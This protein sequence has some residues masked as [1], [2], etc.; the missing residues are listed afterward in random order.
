MI[1]K[2]DASVT[3]YF[4]S[5]YVSSPELTFGFL[6]ALE[7]PERIAEVVRGLMER[8]VVSVFRMEPMSGAD[9]PP[10]RYVVNWASIPQIAITTAAPEPDVLHER[11]TMLINAFLSESGEISLYSAEGKT[12]GR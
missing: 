11:R 7:D 1:A 2:I 6:F 8:Q 4:V 10:E 9:G 5:A 3:W 12:P